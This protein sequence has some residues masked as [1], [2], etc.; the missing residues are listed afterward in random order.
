[1]KS[2]KILTILLSL[3][4]MFTF[5][6]AMAFAETSTDGQHTWTWDAGY[7]G[8]TIDGEHYNTIRTWNSTDGTVTAVPDTTGYSGVYTTG[9]S[10]TY[11][12]LDNAVFGTAT[13]SGGSWTNITATSGTYLKTA[14]Y[15]RPT[16]LIFSCPSYV[17]E[18]SKNTNVRFIQFGTSS[19]TSPCLNSGSWQGTVKGDEDYVPGSTEDQSF[20]L[21]VD[22]S[23]RT[24]G[25]TTE[26]VFSGKVAD[27]P[28]TVKGKDASADNALFFMDKV[29]TAAT[30]Q[31]TLTAKYTGA[32]HTIVMKDLKG[33][34]VK[35]T[36]F[37]TKT[38]E[39]DSVDAVTIKDKG[40]VT[41][42]GT[43]YGADGKVVKK[44]DNTDAIYTLT[45]TVEAAGAR[46]AFDEDPTAT[47]F[48]IPAGEEYDPADFVF[49]YA[50][51]GSDLATNKKAVA[52]DQAE[53][54]AFFKDFAKFTT[55]IKKAT[56]DIE[57]VEYAFNSDLTPAEVKALKTKYATLMSN[58]G[59]TSDGLISSTIGTDSQRFTRVHPAAD[60]E[61]E[62]VSTPSSKIY[63]GSKTTK[64][65]KLKKNQSFTVKAV[66]NTGAEVAYKLIN[67]N[68]KIVIDK[69]T[70]KIT[71]KKGLA[72][73]TYKIKVKAYT[74]T[75]K[76]S[77]GKAF[78]ETQ[79]ITIK[80]KK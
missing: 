35:Y 33:F 36:V 19:T 1:M 44:S 42:K 12:D 4:I 51:T 7:G 58:Y 63:K 40:S 41:F 21:S 53:L 32:D 69:T 66:A 77:D 29:D 38:N 75:V 9:I 76:D 80:V 67:A 49:A 45:A 54:M 39:W 71:V 79:D 17:S 3:A 2:K 47:E 52:A 74:T 24:S 5:M 20:T 46:F 59:M 26:R 23:Y 10:V 78:Y 37:N 64:K 31:P 50:A 61:I 60:T 65:G 30:S 13:Y 34:T 22:V 16:G 55:T 27:L 56:P 62:F 70:G 73:G 8:I 25:I 14:T 15:T 11:H 48:Q 43:L 68:S 72:K 57:D 18:A 28:V 6:P